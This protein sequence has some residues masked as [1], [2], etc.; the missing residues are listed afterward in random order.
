MKFKIFI[1]IPS[2]S[3]VG[4][5][6]GAIALANQLVTDNKVVLVAIKPGLGASA[7]VDPRVK[8]VCLYEY[9][10]TLFSKAK[11]YRSLF[12]RPED[13]HV[14]VS[15]SMGFS[16]DIVNF[17]CKGLALT[18]SSVRGNLPVNYKLDYGKKGLLLAYFHLFILRRFELITAMTMEMSNQIIK[19]TKR[20]PE[21]IGN[22]IDET[23]LLPYLAAPKPLSK[24]INI[25]FVGS[26]SVRKC[27]LLLIDAVKT[28]RD[29]G[30][31]L[32]LDMLGDGPLR[33]D[34]NSKVKAY[35]LSDVIK[36]HGQ[37]GSPFSIVRNAS[38]FVLP[39]LSEGVSRAAMEA[40]FLGTP[41]V[42]RAVDGNHSLV[43]DGFNGAIFKDD[44]ELMDSILRA[45]NLSADDKTQ[46]F[47]P[48]YYRQ[49][50]ETYKFL[51]LLKSNYDKT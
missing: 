40:L 26:L 1:L 32:S 3:P 43:E 9:A 11:E 37:I 34:V 22:F 17:F 16:A 45:V 48:S 20:Q 41:V 12:R 8:L 38:V 39:S 27:P 30:Y 33:D 19:F 50:T 47:L 44:D 29:R 4:P 10:S 13:G 14:L 21:I 51:K 35:G 6:K 5:V 49:S 7:H 36:V 24:R 31:D 15:I 46:N 25:V 2:L 42:I 28:L 23:A 18:V